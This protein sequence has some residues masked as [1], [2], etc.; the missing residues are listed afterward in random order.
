MKELT[1]WLINLPRYFGEFGG[2]LTTPIQI[3]NVS[4]T[5]LAMFGAS[6]GVFVAV[7]VALKIKNL[8]I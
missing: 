6:A 3:G 5:P 7:L 4:L 1:E 8:I 2:W